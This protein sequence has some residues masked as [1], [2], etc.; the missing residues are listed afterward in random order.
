MD[1]L[2]EEYE[3]TGSRLHAMVRPIDPQA[4]AEL[5]AT[6]FES[7]ASTPLPCP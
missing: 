1:C 3:R 6:H 2:R 4:A 5:V 7:G